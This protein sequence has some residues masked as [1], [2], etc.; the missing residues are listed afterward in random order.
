MRN[1]L[2]GVSSC[3]QIIDFGAAWKLPTGNLTRP[4]GTDLTP[5]T[6][7]GRAMLV[8]RLGSRVAWR[9]ASAVV[10]MENML[11]DQSAYSTLEP[12]VT[13]SDAGKVD[14][15]ASYFDLNQLNMNSCYGRRWALPDVLKEKFAVYASFSSIQS[16]RHISFYQDPFDNRPTLSSAQR[17]PPI[18]SDHDTE[19]SSLVRLYS[20]SPAA[21]QSNRT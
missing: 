8:T 21:C 2:T 6:R 13:I 15:F 12:R 5:I 4:W 17:L 10:M 16:A 20:S 7:I 3:H 9:G 1:V 18:A 11:H 19:R 14:R